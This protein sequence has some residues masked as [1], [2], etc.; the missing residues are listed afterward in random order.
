MGAE[1]I[2]VRGWRWRVKVRFLR[3]FDSDLGM[4]VFGSV[5]VEVVSCSASRVSTMYTSAKVF[6]DL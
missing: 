4:M 3:R 1:R 2:G 5:G 6:T